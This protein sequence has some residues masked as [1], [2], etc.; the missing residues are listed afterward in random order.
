M[1]KPYVVSG[2]IDILLERWAA[3]RQF[4]LPNADFFRQLRLEMQEKLTRIFGDAIILPSDEI[5]RNAHSFVFDKQVHPVITLDK[6]YNSSELHLEL[7]R[8]VKPDLS[9]NGL[10]SRYGLP[11]I[12]T[13]VANLMKIQVPDSVAP[14]S[15]QHFSLYDDVI[16]T[17]HLIE[18][19]VEEI[20]SHGMIVG[21]IGCGVGIKTG[22]DKLREKG[23]EV[24]VFREYAEVIDQVCERDFYPG[25][26]YS[27][28]TLSTDKQVGIPYL[29]PFGNPMT[30]A[31]IPIGHTRDFSDFCL[32]QTTKLF[33]T[34]EMV[35][36]KK[37]GCSDIERKL[38]G[39]PEDTSRFV[40]FLEKAR[41]KI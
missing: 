33:K 6:V 8:T 2:D 19:I 23:L 38:P 18:S 35:S 32:H 16:F 9:D 20:T 5:E 28:R 27:G 22:L 21:S 24:L 25:V 36:G 11:D 29:L 39:L 1:Y 30:W 7:T 15:S 3:R 14:K 41:E 13:Q 40:D 17:G 4:T 37:V 10:D 34:I 31:S 26:S 12:Q